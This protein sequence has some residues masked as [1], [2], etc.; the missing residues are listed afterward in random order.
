MGDNNT[1]SPT[2]QR[3]MTRL[4]T[5]DAALGGTMEQ[6]NQCEMR[7]AAFKPS[8]LFAVIKRSK[9]PSTVA[10]TKR[11]S[12]VAVTKRSARL[13]ATK[14]SAMLAVNTVPLENSFN[15][16]VALKPVFVEHPARIATA[17]SH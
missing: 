5:V 16:T 3:I 13:A 9:R 6:L 12:T 2:L 10:V 1:S 15:P 8:S 4:T 11:S 17:S 14:R 7:V